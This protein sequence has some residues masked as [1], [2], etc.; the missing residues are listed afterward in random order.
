MA[1]TRSTQEECTERY[2]KF[3]EYMSKVRQHLI[4][5]HYKDALVADFRCAI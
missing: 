2:A 4:T 3:K 5:N 1:R